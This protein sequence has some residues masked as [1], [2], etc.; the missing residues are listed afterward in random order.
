MSQS[1]GA[2]K[3]PLCSCSQVQVGEDEPPENA[4]KRFR[5]AAQNTGLVMEVGDLRLAVWA[6]RLWNL[7]SAAG[8]GKGKAYDASPDDAAGQETHAL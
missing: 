1:G 6:V 5:Y 4:L 2:G 8:R 3:D 7:R